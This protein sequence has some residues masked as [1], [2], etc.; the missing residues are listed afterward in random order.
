MGAGGS[1]AA[2]LHDRRAAAG[3]HGSRR[4]DL[5]RARAPAGVLVRALRNAPPGA[6]LGG[7]RVSD[8]GRAGVDR[9][10]SGL[11]A[12][13]GAGA[14]PALADDRGRPGPHG[15][16]A[17]ARGSRSLHRVPIN[18]RDRPRI[19]HRGRARWPHRRLEPAGRARLRLVSRR[20]DRARSRCDRDPPEGPGGLRGGLRPAPAFRRPH[21]PRQ[22]VRDAGHA[23]RR[24]R[25][26]GRDHGLGAAQ[27]RWVQG[28][29]V[30]SRHLR[31]PAGRTGAAR[32]RGTV[33]PLIPRQRGGNGDR[34]HGRELAAGESGARR[35]DRDTPG[36]S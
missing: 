13:R 10:R 32:G 4:V 26:P 21:G 3:R 11:P 35:P 29:R 22:A 33:P 31:A 6:R 18:P 20:G 23:P 14:R 27:W 15:A 8:P 1:A 16:S 28:Q 36:R 34:Q 12:R 19:V 7:R 30:P 2:L 5:H 9:R 25:V 24:R 17:R